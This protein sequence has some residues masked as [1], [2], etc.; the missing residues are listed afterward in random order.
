M[1]KIK[2][3]AVSQTGTPEE[4]KKLESYLTASEQD[5]SREVGRF[6]E[7]NRER[8]ELTRKVVQEINAEMA[9]KPQSASKLRVEGARFLNMAAQIQKYE[10]GIL[11]VCGAGACL[12]Q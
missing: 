8:L 2:S 6:R 7:L 10:A 1:Q 11:H 5:L 9:Q 3:Q 12:A 4:I